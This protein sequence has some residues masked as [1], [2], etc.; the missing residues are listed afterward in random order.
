MVQKLTPKSAQE[1]PGDKEVR[2]SKARFT[3]EKRKNAPK[4]QRVSRQDHKYTAAI[5]RNIENIMAARVKHE[6]GVLRVMDIPEN[7]YE[8]AKGGAYVAE[9]TYQQRNS[10]VGWRK[11]KIADRQRDL[12]LQLNKELR[13]RKK[14]QLKT[15]LEKKQKEVEEAKKRK[16]QRRDADTVKK[17][18]EPLP[19]NDV[20]GAFFDDI[21][22]INY[23]DYVDDILPEEVGIKN[24]K[25][26][27]VISKNPVIKKSGL[28][29]STIVIQETA[30][31]NENEK[32][33][34][35][36]AAIAQNDEE[37]DN[38]NEDE[39]TDKE[40]KKYKKKK[41]LKAKATALNKL[42]ELEKQEVQSER[43]APSAP[44]NFR[45][46]N[47]FDSVALLDEDF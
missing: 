16:K 21:L 46:V 13:L 3:S 24:K 38:I 30:L 12:Q 17:E 15:D 1:R 33:S 19:K 37:E 4:Q 34:A 43:I 44:Q 28:K 32:D 45:G 14:Q 42:K 40:L 31:V 5:T 7:V 47:I 6:G 25:G 8:Y 39:M 20:A 41:Q 35:A 26:L 27:P 2:T 36:A 22:N 9:K 23:D 18:I 10:Q 11:T 29:I